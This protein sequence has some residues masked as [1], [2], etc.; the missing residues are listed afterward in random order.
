MDFIERWIAINY[1]KKNLGHENRWKRSEIFQVL[2]ESASE[3]FPQDNAISIFSFLVLCLYQEMG[4][5]ED[6]DVKE[7]FAS[8]TY[9]A[10]LNFDDT[11]DCYIHGRID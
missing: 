8:A 4:Q 2:F 10:I 3:T 7:V 1:I 6:K 11:K 9:R 5:S